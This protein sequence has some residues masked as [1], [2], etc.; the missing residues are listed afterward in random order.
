MIL[1]NDAILERNEVAVSPEDR[2]YYFGDGVYEVF[3]LYNGRLFE[4]E[5]H[6]ERLLRSAREIRLSLP[7]SADKLTRRLDDLVQASGVTEGT[8]YLQITRGCAPRAHG[9]PAE[10]TPV[11][12]AYCTEAARPAA[13][14]ERGITAVTVPDIRWLRCDIKSLNLLP[15][16]LAKQE[17]A[18]RG[19]NEVVLHRNGT[20]TECSASN[21]MI[22][23]D[24]AIRTHPA[25]NLILHGITRKVVFRLAQELA[26]P[27]E[28]E[29][30]SI[31]ELLAAEEAF[32]TGT[33]VEVT[34]VIEVDGR[35]IGNGRPG[36]VTRLLQERF[37]QEIARQTGRL[38]N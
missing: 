6:K 32:V 23:R 3:R 9:F 19:V 2:G 30:F 17:A 26:L 25:N 14:M 1:Y 38:P 36:P 10:C 33:T 18:D 27:V 20:V 24:G 35:R 31:E 11:L 37:V 13:G 22:V 7:Y 21:L 4:P 8:L 12:M 5:A 34:P 16:V 28:E 15:N 29:P